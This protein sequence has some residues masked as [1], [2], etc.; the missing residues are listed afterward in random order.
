[1][2]EL[3]ALLFDL[4]GT[5]VDTADANYAAYAMAL[6]EAGITIGRKA[7]DRAATGCHWRQFLPGL[8][9]AADADPAAIASRKREI[10]LGMA[11]HTRLNHALAELAASLCA[12]LKLGV[13]TSAS[14]SSAEAV[15]DA[16]GLRALF[17]TVVTGDDVLEPKPAPDAYLLAAARLGVSPGECLALE[18]S[19]TGLKSA[20]RA[21]MRTLRVTFPATKGAFESGGIASTRQQASVRPS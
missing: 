6:R 17:A 12:R 2:P 20:R 11:A 15:L 13:V 18:D 4:D 9:G 8:I 21:G 10:Y 3:T 16:H 7:F 1:L 14:R 19:E 5:L